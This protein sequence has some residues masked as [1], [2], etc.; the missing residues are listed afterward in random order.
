MR[1]LIFPGALLLGKILVDQP[2]ISTFN[3]GPEAFLFTR[4]E[5]QERGGDG[6]WLIG[7]MCLDNAHRCCK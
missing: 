7:Q 3:P 6:S 1:P 4:D 5:R 2:G